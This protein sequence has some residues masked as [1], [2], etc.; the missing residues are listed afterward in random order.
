MFQLTFT[1]FPFHLATWPEH[2][3]RQ[4]AMRGSLELDIANQIYGPIK[5]IRFGILMNHPET[6]CWLTILPAIIKEVHISCTW[7]YFCSVHPY[8][9][10]NVCPLRSNPNE[11]T[12]RN[13]LGSEVFGRPTTKPLVGWP[14]KH[15]F[16]S[17]LSDDSPPRISN[18]HEW[19][20]YI[21]I[22]YNI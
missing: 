17:L 14:G 6:D 7:M 19:I 22:I 4:T 9:S 12:W 13:T 10:F 18:H 21:Y 1:F 15:G 16:W 11:N 3:L 8:A 5:S 20:I 2:H